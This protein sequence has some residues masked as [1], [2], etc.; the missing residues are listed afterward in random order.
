M[1]DRLYGMPFK[2]RFRFG[3]PGA[4]RPLLRSL[5]LL[6]SKRERPALNQLLSRRAEETSAEFV[7]KH[8]RSAL[9]FDAR[10]PLQQFAIEEAPKDGLLLEF[11]VFKGRSI[12]SFAHLLRNMGD[13]RCIWGFD[14]F[15]GLQEHWNGVGYHRSRNKFNLG[16]QLP[17]VADNVRLVP[18]WI[19]DTLPGFLEQHP[20]PIAFLHIDTD[21]YLPAKTILRLCKPRLQAGSLIL[22]DELLAYPG[23]QHGEYRALIEEMPESGYEWIGFGFTCAL[24]RVG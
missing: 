16:G 15:R 21:T 22:F 8:L 11:G 9:L 4:L 5:G 2:F 23:W 10:E 19:D 13:S 1:A 20:G 3:V 18:G 24:L 6:P 12:N 14:A 7:E 17:E